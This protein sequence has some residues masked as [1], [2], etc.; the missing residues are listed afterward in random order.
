MKAGYSMKSSIC[1]SI[2][3]VDYKG[4]TICIQIADNKNFYS[5]ETEDSFTV[6][7][8]QNFILRYL[9]RN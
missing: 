1:I 9:A 6:H 2:E 8:L 5:P 7:Q 3:K 4:N